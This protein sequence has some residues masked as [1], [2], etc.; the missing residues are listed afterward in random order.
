MVCDSR[1]GTG[2]RVEHVFMAKPQA[3]KVN[4]KE[5]EKV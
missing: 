1:R 2:G 3:A 4:T 5:D